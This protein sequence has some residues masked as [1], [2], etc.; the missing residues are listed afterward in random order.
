MANRS[1]EVVLQ[2]LT[3]YWDWTQNKDGDI[4]IIEEQEDDRVKVTKVGHGIF[5]DVSESEDKK[6]VTFEI[7]E[8]L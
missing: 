1:I 8:T 5:K 4:L 3:F 6:V 7:D 2:P